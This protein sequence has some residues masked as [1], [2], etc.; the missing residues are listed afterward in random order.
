MKKLVLLLFLLASTLTFGQVIVHNQPVKLKQLVLGTSA[1]SLVVVD[2][3]G[4]T[5]YLPTSVIA[6]DGFISSGG[7][8]VDPNEDRTGRLT[9]G[10]GSLELMG[11]FDEAIYGIT[12]NF[13]V[14]GTY[15]MGVGYNNVVGGY[16]NLAVGD[17]NEQS[18][19]QSL[20]VGWRNRIVGSYNNVAF[21]V[22]QR[23]SGQR[24][25]LAGM[26][27]NDFG[28]HNTFLLGITLNAENMQDV[29]V[30]GEANTT[31]TADEYKFI[32]GN[33]TVTGNLTDN[34]DGHVRNGLG[35]DAFIVRTD[36]RVIAP[37]FD[38]GLYS[39]VKDLTTVE[40]VTSMI[41]ANSVD[42]LDWFDA[43]TDGK[44]TF[45]MDGNPFIHNYSGNTTNAGNPYYQNTFI[46]EDAGNMTV[47]D[48]SSTL[49][50]GMI[51]VGIGAWA[52]NSLTLGA[53]NVM[54]GNEAGALM[55]VANENVGIGDGAFYYSVTGVNNNMGIGKN[56][57]QN[58]T[59]GTYNVGMG[60]NSGF[61][62][63]AGTTFTSGN[64]HTLIGQ[65]TRPSANGTTNEIVIGS[66]ARG[67][68][69]NT[70]VIGSSAIT[71]ISAGA[72]FVAVNP[73]DLVTKGYADATYS[74]GGGGGTI[75]GTIADTQVA[76]GNGTDA[77]V[78][79]N[80]F[81]ANSTS[82][83]IDSLRMSGGINLPFTGQPGLGGGAIWK[84]GSPF[85][86]TTAE[87]QVVPNTFIGLYAGNAWQTHGD[88]ASASND[89][90]N[91]G[92]GAYSLWSMTGESTQNVAVGS[93]S[94]EVLTTGDWNT[95]VGAGGL[96]WNNGSKNTGIG[97]NA[98]SGNKLGA[99]NVFIGSN[100]GIFWSGTSQTLDSTNNGIYIGES[101][102]AGANNV[103]DEIVIGR[104]AVGNGSNTATI[105][106]SSTID[107][108]L[109]GTTNSNAFEIPKTVNDTVG[110][111]RYEGQHFIHSYT[112]NP[113]AFGQTFYANLF[114]GQG[115]G[116]FTVGD[117]Q[118]GVGLDSG[119]NNT[120]FGPF[121]LSSLTTGTAN[122]SM[123][124][125]SLFSNT[126]GSVNTA[127]GSGNLYYNTTG[128][129]NT[130]MGGAAM[131]N[132]TTASGNTA[133]GKN[134]LFNLLTG[135]SNV[136]IG[137]NAGYYAGATAIG[138]M[139]TGDENIL[140]GYQARV[141]SNGINNATAIGQD[142]VAGASNTVTLGSST[143]A[144][145]S[146]GADFVATAN[147]D[148]IT[149]GYFDAN[150]QLVDPSG[151]SNL[152][153]DG[154]LSDWTLGAGITHNA[155]TFDFATAFGIFQ[156]DGAFP[157]KVVEGASY[158]VT[159]NVATYSAGTMQVSVGGSTYT[160]AINGLGSWQI[161]VVAGGG[162]SLFNAS[163]PVA[164]TGS[165]DHITIELAD[166]SS[167][168]GVGLAD[169]NIWTGTNDFNGQV[170]IGGGGRILF[171]EFD[172]GGIYT[173]N[174]GLAGSSAFYM[175]GGDAV[176]RSVDAGGIGDLKYSFDDSVGMEMEFNDL[177]NSADANITY[178]GLGD[179]FIIN[180]ATGG[181]TINGNGQ[182]AAP[183]KYVLFQG[184]LPTTSFTLDENH[185]G[186]ILYM[187]NTTD[188]T[189]TIATTSGFTVGSQVSIVQ[190]GTGSVTIAGSGITLLKKPTTPIT[191]GLASAVQVVL[192]DTGKA[193]VYGDLIDN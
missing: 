14:S 32:I 23:L 192:Y 151:S 130:A 144:K 17:G 101:S 24:N 182:M 122:V 78:G 1:D 129:N 36:G 173:D 85:I 145:V 168:G 53:K 176:M 118:T 169:N 121:T 22:N 165:I 9:I 46:G 58:L 87:N 131:Q 120:G 41:G 8:Y 109:K 146:A 11:Y 174:Q 50:E 175:F 25:L 100:A 149:K 63:N 172:S 4:L 125:E 75:G 71:K 83:S 42:R 90:N 179:G 163:F 77:I 52:L 65:D 138:Q 70:A 189:I 160:G 20:A 27:N 111:L 59:T 154:Y 161:K 7:G 153:Y 68:G 61:F 128:S 80:G 84:N 162:S 10:Q 56:V 103:T 92:V 18:G 119:L 184:T 127:F 102:R 12:P 62:I 45:T 136:A 166:P 55:T 150:T 139:T 34:P 38:L 39:D 185:R 74:G 186:R 97:R 28:A 44:Y 47:G 158:L 64:Y 171:D 187:E 135:E 72:D 73:E 107:V 82:V 93:S 89:G 40:K 69:S 137:H 16:S 117:G 81:T 191:N 159:I 51:N 157:F 2:G 26:G 156:Y 167:G 106:N 147:K 3:T 19:E 123:G 43:E 170:T 181:L 178:F 104:N 54:I 57:F 177:A 193:H 108:Y 5:K 155:H 96:Y 76:Y 99:N 86:F 110:A 183:F 133:I 105:G 31:Q 33:G 6:G 88:F 29:V 116:N 48:G 140:I 13:G 112:G 60:R 152:A 37:S 94:L 126:T 49:G 132:S 30:I 113:D 91:V 79:R 35:S 114:V 180:N 143:I 148:L 188:I 67:K 134:T 21:G 190:A 142:A 164:M 66:A 115:A 141:G 95:A 15:S 124:N 98:G